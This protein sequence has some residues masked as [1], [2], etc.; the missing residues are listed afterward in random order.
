VDANPAPLTACVAHP[1]RCGY[2]D[3]SNTGPSSG[4][5][6]KPSGSLRVSTAGSVVS[7]LDIHGSL[8]ITAAD[9]VVR[10]VRVTCDSSCAG[11]FAIQGSARAT[12]LQI[13]HVEASSAPDK[14]VIATAADIHIT[15]A[16]IHNGMDGVHLTSGSTMTDSYVHDLAPTSDSHDDTIQ[17]IESVSSHI[18]IHHN[19]LLPYNEA[20]RVFNNSAF[21]CGSQCT[22]TTYLSFTDNL[23]NGGSITVRCP[24]KGSQGNVFADNR[25]GRNFRFSAAG[26]GCAL[27]GNSWIR[28]IYDDDHSAVT[29]RGA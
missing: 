5:A 13:D 26:P 8:L 7:G 14:T 4:V 29:P 1:S 22:S 21:I 28:N 2:P 24:L 25:F 27:P 19:T 17:I 16:N 3:A 15:A 12:G 23:V 18:V 20:S 10:N 6:L 9:V 11:R